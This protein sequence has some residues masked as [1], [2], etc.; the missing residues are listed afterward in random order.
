MATPPAAARH[1]LLPPDRR[2]H[3]LKLDNLP[4]GPVSPGRSHSFDLWLQ[5]TGVDDWN[6]GYYALSYQICQYGVCN[7]N[8]TGVHRQPLNVNLSP[9][10]DTGENSPVSINA[11]FPSSLHQ[12]P[13]T[14]RF[15][16]TKLSSPWGSVESWFSAGGW[17]TQNVSL[18]VDTCA[19]H[20]PAVEKR[21]GA[22]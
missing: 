22:Q 12:G 20:L 6:A 13:V 1:A 4:T 21:F 10:D 19:I 9:G 5:N 15:D 18:C 7:I 11:L 16:M 3:A 14:V 17:P 8:T 2:W